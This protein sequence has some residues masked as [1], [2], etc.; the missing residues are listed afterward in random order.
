MVRS[1]LI[2]DMSL[3]VCFLSSMHAPTD[4][5]VFQKEARTLAMAGF[6]V[7][8]LAPGDEPN[9][10]EDGVWLEIYQTKKT[11]TS[12]FFSLYRLYKRA[13]AIE[14]NVYHCN[15]VDSWFVGIALKYLRRKVVVFDVHEHYPSTFAR[16][17][18]PRPLQTIVEWSMRM[19]FKILTPM[20]DFFVFAKKTVE[21]DFPRSQDRSVTLLNCAVLDGMQE[22]D[23]PPVREQS[24]Y[25]TAIHVGVFSKERGWPQLLEGLRLQQS[26][27]LR[28]KIIGTCTDRS[29]DDFQRAI[30]DDDMKDRIEAIDWLPFDEMYREL[31]LADIGLVLFQPGIQ[32]H[33]FAMPHKM[34]DYMKA[35]LPV[36]APAFAMEVAPI[37]KEADCGILI[38]PSNPQ[39]IADALDRL[40]ED[41]TLRKKYG[42]RGRSAVFRRYN[43]EE[44]GKQLVSLYKRVTQKCQARQ[45]AA[46]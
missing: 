9:R 18:S 26:K 27:N 38:D 19:M 22:N 23:P 1:V 35:R 11:I 46:R 39:E 3:K 28:V 5:R 6:D 17:H 25:V 16:Q 32:N 37:I 42:E 8:H 41:V 44:E 13:S 4:K 34:F 7:V 15:E 30:S 24:E 36:I 43:W 20:T 21:P 29:A 12:R 40:V 10:T 14:A 45:G 33:V 2:E 31:E